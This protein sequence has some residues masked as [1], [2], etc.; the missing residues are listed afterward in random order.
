MT[1]VVVLTHNRLAVTKLFVEAIYKNTDQ[2]SFNLIFVDNASTDGTPEYLLEE[3][4]NRN[5]CVLTMD[6]NTG[7]IGGRNIG[8]K[9]VVSDYF[10]NLDNDQLPQENWLQTLHNRMN[11]R[12][13][14]VGCEAWRMTPAKPTPS[15]TIS[16]MRRPYYPYY[17]CTKPGEHFHYIGCGGMLI[18]KNVYK[19]VG[20]KENDGSLS[21]FD[22]RFS[23]AYFEDP[24]LSWRAIQAGFKLAW[25]PNCKIKHLA[26]QTIN[27]Q[28]T[29]DKGKQFIKS[30][31]AFRDKWMPYHPG[32]IRTE[33]LNE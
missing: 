11:D 7:V 1:D 2:E 21:L 4:K 27:T 3:S 18:R 9:A 33:D 12:Y 14:I 32:D 16:T 24:D 19:K 28:R 15:T 22:T 10:V 29:F 8:A 23:P 6:E 26:H 31:M 30:W 17:R 20:I 13:D 25:E 5:W